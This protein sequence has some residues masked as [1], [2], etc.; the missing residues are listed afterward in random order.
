[1]RAAR[2]R[3][4]DR[5][6]SQSRGRNWRSRSRSGDAPLFVIGAPRTGGDESESDEDVRIVPGRRERKG[7]GCIQID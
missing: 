7:S 5:E 4:E 1:M 6:R 2:R 3:Q